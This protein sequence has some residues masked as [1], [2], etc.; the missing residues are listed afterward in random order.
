MKTDELIGLL[1]AAGAGVDTESRRRSAHH[2]FSARLAAGFL[3]SLIAML[4][5]LGPRPDWREAIELPMFWV[6][7]AFPAG[8]AVA[9]CWM[10]R[11]LGHPGMAVGMIAA[12]AMAVPV[13]V[14][15]SLASLT[16]FSAEPASRISLIMGTS[17]WQCVLSIALLALPAFLL[18]CWALRALAPTRL[19]LTGAVAGAFAGSIGGLVYALH[20]PEMEAPFLAIWYVLGMLLPAGIGALLGRRLLRW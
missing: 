14:V 13:A 6:K 5:V 3:V 4:I 2:A 8:I 18:A 16:L 20:C 19:S 12:L 15:W 11:R 7:L 9:A 10:L 1:S 17:W